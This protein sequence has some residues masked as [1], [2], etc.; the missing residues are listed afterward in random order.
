MNKSSITGTLKILICGVFHMDTFSDLDKISIQRE[1]DKKELLNKKINIEEKMDKLNGWNNDFNFR[2]W[3]KGD[4]K[5]SREKYFEQLLNEEEIDE[6]DLHDEGSEVSAWLI[7]IRP[8]YIGPAYNLNKYI[9]SFVQDVFWTDIKYEID[10][11]SW[12]SSSLR[13]TEILVEFQNCLV[14]IKMGL[15]RMIKL[16]SLY[17]KG[18]SPSTTFGHIDITEEGIEKGKNFMAYVMSNKDKDEF[19]AFI[20]KEYNEWIN[21]CVKPRDAIIHYQDFYSIYTFDAE[22]GAEYPNHFNQKK[23]ESIEASISRIEEYV[24]RYYVFYEKILKLLIKK[25]KK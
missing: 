23:D 16:F 11:D 25:E 13:E 9:D 15:D 7:C 24:N 18:F 19:F 12:K 2:L 4:E 20:Y 6:E 14:S 3:M 5:Y 22:T 10:E 1:R 17:Y 21:K 8:S